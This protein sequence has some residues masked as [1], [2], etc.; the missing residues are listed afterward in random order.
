MRRLCRHSQKA[1]LEH[2][3]MIRSAIGAAFDLTSRGRAASG[4]RKR[5]GD[6]KVELREWQWNFFRLDAS[7]AARETAADH[8]HVDARFSALI[9]RG[10]AGYGEFL[11]LSAAAIYPVEQALIAGD[12]ERLL[13]DWKQRARKAAL[14][15][16][17]ED[18]GIENPRFR[19]C[20]RSAEKRNYSAPCTFW[21]GPGLVPECWFDDCRRPLIPH[22]G[23]Q[24]VIS[25]M[26][27]ASRFGEA[28]WR[29]WSRPP[30]L[31]VRRRTPLRGRTWP[32]RALAVTQRLTRQPRQPGSG[33]DRPLARPG[34][35]D[36]L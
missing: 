34:R 21:K 23:A 3:Y 11:R 1:R 24:C 27:R 25:I 16:D 26:A 32:L 14:N 30:S 13:P 10:T 6:V 29:G 17:L 18:L 22:P 7:A 12:I 5:P 20:R 9:G 28:S 36:Q 4:A 31:S 15:A 35:S 33:H 2:M 8:A 19:S